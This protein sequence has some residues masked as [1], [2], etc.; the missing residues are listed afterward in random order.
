M[1]TLLVT[2]T[3]LEKDVLI[4]NIS[5]QIKRI[6]YGHKVRCAAMHVT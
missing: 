5:K 3:R 1:H 4:C 6:N 2:L